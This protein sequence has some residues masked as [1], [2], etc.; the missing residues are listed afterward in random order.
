MTFTITFTQ[1]AGKNKP[2]NQDALFNGV[3]VFQYNLKKAAEFVENRPH[4]LLGVADGVSSSPNPHRASRFWMEQLQQCTALNSKWV[5]EIHSAFCDA[6][7]ETHFGTSTT[8]VVAE[9]AQNGRCKILNVGD[10]R[11]Y[12]IDS[13]GRWQQ[14]SHDHIV[15][16]ELLQNPSDSTEY[17]QMYYALSDCLIA[18]FEETEFKIHTAE[19][20]LEAGECLLLCSDGLTDDVPEKVRLK[21][22]QNFDR[23]LDR[24][25]ALRRYAKRQALYDGFSVV[26]AKCA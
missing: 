13:Q 18:D 2:H 22:W 12:K 10:S 11:T 14:L 16:D 19:C 4:F 9:I 1:Q 20:Q 25:N 24:L 6:L 26:V 21:I 15:L 7:A 17:A 8:L 3:E 23:T 5:R